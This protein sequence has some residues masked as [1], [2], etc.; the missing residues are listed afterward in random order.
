MKYEYWKSQK[1]GNW[2]WHLKAA[3]NQVIATGEGYINKADVLTV[4]K[5]V[6]GASLAP[7]VN[8]TP[9]SA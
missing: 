6:K 7:E 2:Y 9:T 3:N 1:N 8:L 5:L 4:I